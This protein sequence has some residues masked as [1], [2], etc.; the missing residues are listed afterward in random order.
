MGEQ[1][2]MMAAQQLA[3]LSMDGIALGC[4]LLA[5]KHAGMGWSLMENNAMT[6]ILIQ[7]MDVVTRLVLKTMVIVVI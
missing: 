2:Q 4:Q 1:D 6:L 7:L 5:I 3:R